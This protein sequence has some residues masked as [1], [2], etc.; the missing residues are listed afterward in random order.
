MDF[1]VEGGA[2]VFHGGTPWPD[3]RPGG[4][5]VVDALHAALSAREPV[6]A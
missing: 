6:P 4:A 3:L 1:A 2:W 5:A